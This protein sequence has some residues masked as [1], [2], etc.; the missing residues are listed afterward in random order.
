MRYTADLA[1]QKRHL[2]VGRTCQGASRALY[3]VQA[4]IQPLHTLINGP[5][6]ALADAL[7]LQELALV[8]RQQEGLNSSSLPDKQTEGMMLNSTVI[9]EVEADVTQLRLFSFFD[10]SPNLD[11]LLSAFFFFNE[12]V[13]QKSRKSTWQRVILDKTRNE[14]ADEDDKA[15]SNASERKDFIFVP[16]MGRKLHLPLQT[17]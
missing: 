9:S 11:I 12:Q 14:G 1:G 17:K 13:L 15:Q 3:C 8:A 5:E 10:A 7:Q 6:L 16:L 2:L 4:A